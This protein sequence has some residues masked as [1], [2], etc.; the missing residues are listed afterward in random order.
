MNVRLQVFNEVI[1]AINH[2]YDIK[3]KRIDVKTIKKMNNIEKND[4]SKT[5]FYNFVLRELIN[6]GY[7]EKKEKTYYRILKKVDKVVIPNF[8][9]N[10]KH[11]TKRLE[12][13]RNP[14]NLN[15]CYYCGKT[16]TSRNKT[17]HINVSR[18]IKYAFC[19]KECKIKWI[20]KIQ[21]QNN[22]KKRSK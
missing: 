17:Y 18:Q 1:S 22:K 7:I 13:P 16:I 2:R 12:E 3:Y 21:R 11:S 15:I 8:Q 4:R 14:L 9:N 20:Y 5:S 19:N 10:K 6:Q